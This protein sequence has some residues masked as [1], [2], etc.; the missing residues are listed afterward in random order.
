MNLSFSLGSGVASSVTTK[1][2]AGYHA[3][4]LQLR[5]GSIVVAG[6]I[7]VVR[8]LKGETTVGDFSFDQINPPAVSMQVNFAPVIADPLVVNLSG[9][10]P[11]VTEGT[12]VTVEAS[13]PGA[14]V[15]LLYTWY[16]DGAFQTTG[17][18]F[19]VAPTL[20]EGPHR[21]DVTAFTADGM[22][23]GTAYHSFDVVAA[24]PATQATLAWDPNGEPDLLGYRLYYGTQSGVYDHIID[25]GNVVTYT[26][27]GLEL[28][29]TYFFAVTAYNGDESGYSNEV[30]FDT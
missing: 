4:S 13:V 11:Q 6:A 10:L 2:Q 16:L 21:I 8:I 9:T 29:R 24:P 26:V 15:N 1:V 25:V 22:Q 14:T 7:E 19:A 30:S 27:T 23:A 17:S 18:S 28:G 20:P 12:E 5:D 3:L